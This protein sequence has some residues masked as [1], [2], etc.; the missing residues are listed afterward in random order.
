MGDFLLFPFA[1]LFL[2]RSRGAKAPLFQ[3]LTLR[4]VGRSRR[5]YRRT[6][7]LAAIRAVCIA[8]TD[9]A[10]TAVADRAECVVTARAKVIVSL[11]RSAALRAALKQRFS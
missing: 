4:R 9:G 1:T 8:G 10:S 5:L 7:P 6:H 2:F 3:S 11:Y